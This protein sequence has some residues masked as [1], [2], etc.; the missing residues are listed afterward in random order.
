MEHPHTFNLADVQ[1]EVLTQQPVGDHTKVRINLGE[2][3][4]FHHN[5]RVGDIIGVA[6]DE[7]IT[8]EKDQK[9][10]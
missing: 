10:H 3:I 1:S 9:Y 7:R 4:V 8:G 6:C 2:D 5:L